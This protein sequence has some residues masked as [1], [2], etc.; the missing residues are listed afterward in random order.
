VGRKSFVGAGTT[1]TDFNLIPKPLRAYMDGELQPI[2][3]DVMGGCVGHN[4]RLGAGL[5]IYPARTIESDTIIFSTHERRVVDKNVTYEE[6]DH[7]QVP[8]GTEMHPRLY[9]PNVRRL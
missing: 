2:G 9:D 4:C 3:S 6:S 5:V 8:G 1:F 7:H